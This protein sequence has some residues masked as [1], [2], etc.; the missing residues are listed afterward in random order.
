[1][2]LTTNYGF[3]KPENNDNVNVDDLNYNMD[4]ADT[5]LKKANEQLGEKVKYTDL[6]PITTTGTSLDYIATIPTNM[7]EV[8]IVPHINNL[9]GATLNSVPILDREGKPIEK[10]V[11]KINIP[12]K[13]VR[14]GSNFFI[15]SGVAG[16]GA[17]GLEGA[18]AVPLGTIPTRASLYRASDN[19]FFNDILIETEGMKGFV[20]ICKYSKVKKSYE[21]LVKLNLK[22]VSTLNLVGATA[23][24]KNITYSTDGSKVYFEIT[25]LSDTQQAV[26]HGIYEVDLTT[27]AY[28]T[29]IEAPVATFNYAPKT[30]YADKDYIYYSA[31]R[32]GIG[33]EYNKVALS[34][35]SKVSFKQGNMYTSINSTLNRYRFYCE[36]NNCIYIIGTDGGKTTDLY[37]IS[38]TTLSM[39]TKKLSAGGGV[40]TTNKRGL[41]SDGTYLYVIT[42]QSTSTTISLYKYNLANFS[43]VSYAANTVTLSNPKGYKVG[44][45]FQ[46]IVFYDKKHSLLW[47]NTSSDY[48]TGSS[49]NF[50]QVVLTA[51]DLNNNYEICDAISLKDKG[52][53]GY[54]NG[55]FAFGLQV[56][57]AM[58]TALY[59]DITVI[60]DIDNNTY[61]QIV[62]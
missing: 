30:L 17:L 3:K 32:E 52:Y 44:R 45:Y 58:F 25:G 41:Y 34:D 6:T 7:T 9:A 61:Y 31:Y 47:V 33:S 23:N 16:G 46:E 53:A 1:M 26:K 20:N 49:T 11:L 62:L 15:A 54:D 19:S 28:R 29:I 4:I 5:E 35:L 60:C 8:T 55:T 42:D 48:Y 12:T 24:I 2:Q 43:L 57:D 59:G 39:T 56:R 40:Y 14:V 18:Y 37:E 27:F 36:A 51:L 13:L 50:S 38:L 22:T 21:I 10:D